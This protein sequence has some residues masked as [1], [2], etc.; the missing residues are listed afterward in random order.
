MPM[1]SRPVAARTC[2]S[3]CRALLPS[4][5]LGI[6]PRTPADLIGWF[7]SPVRPAY[8]HPHPPPPAPIV[9]PRAVA[10]GRADSSRTKQGRIRAS[11]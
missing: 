11:H 7:L 1:R 5:R 2:G 8:L 9:L 3:V 10:G 4:H 6:N